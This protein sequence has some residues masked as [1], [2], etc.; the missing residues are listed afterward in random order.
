MKSRLDKKKIF[1]LPMTQSINIWMEYPQRTYINQWYMKRLHYRRIWRPII[2]TRRISEAKSTA[3]SWQTQPTRR[4][5]LGIWMELQQLS[6][7]FMAKT[8]WS[9]NAEKAFCLVS[10]IHVAFPIEWISQTMF[11]LQIEYQL[12]WCCIFCHGPVFWYR[13]W[14]EMT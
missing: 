14:C 9:A 1:R 3:Q 10:F 12:V 8:Q 2:A 11:H 6:I 13:L 7:G 5:V 4:N